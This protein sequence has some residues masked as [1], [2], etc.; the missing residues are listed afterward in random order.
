MERVYHIGVDLHKRNSQVGV[1][2]NNGEVVDM[3]KLVNDKNL[4]SDYF[5]LFPEGTPVVIE[6]T[7]GWEW[8]CDLLEEKGLEVKLANPYKVKLI[9]ESTIK[10]DKVDAITLAQLER[11]NFLPLSYLAPKVVREYRELLRHRFVL[12][13]IRSSLKNRIHSILTKRGI[14]VE[15][16]TDLFGKK[17]RE[18]LN[19]LE[20]PPIYMEEIKTYL[21]IIN[22]LDTYIKKKDE[23]IK[24]IVKEENAQAKLLT[25]IPG[26]SYLSGLLLVA[27]IGDI[28]R[29]SSS[30]KLC[31]YAGLSPTTS[32]SGEKVY[33]GHLKKDS[34]K[35]IRWV[36]IEAIEH[37]IKKDAVLKYKYEKICREKGINKARVA[38]AQKI[39]ISVYWM[40]KKN[41]PYKIRKWKKNVFRVSPIG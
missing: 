24:K 40:L 14:M 12:V 28:N 10:T 36:L 27:E 29:F 25:S 30:K 31:S 19:S 5:H 20:L 22:K 3:R 7:T 4:L 32:Q 21:D 9:A 33:H 35:Y 41:E 11:T 6:A 18:F 26:I 8:I 38:I 37:V 16:C 2:N 1:V 13:K 17:G 23:Q 39:C 34:N 15:K